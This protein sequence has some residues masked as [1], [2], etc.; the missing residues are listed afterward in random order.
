MN[1]YVEKEEERV[2]IELTLWRDRCHSVVTPPPSSIQTT[3]YL[4]CPPGL[5]VGH[6]EKLIR[7]KFDLPSTHHSV[8][9]F[10]PENNNGVRERFTSE[11]TLSDL[12]CI[13]SCSQAWKR[14]RGNDYLNGITGDGS[15]MKIYF[16]VQ[17]ISG[18]NEVISAASS[19][20][21]ASLTSNPIALSTG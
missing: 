11:F 8:E 1:A 17:P 18:Q 10:F 16:S 12:V 20:A 4:L 21:T 2:S 6:L 14:T 19:A 3:T 7:H 9:L 5:T 13:N 15:P